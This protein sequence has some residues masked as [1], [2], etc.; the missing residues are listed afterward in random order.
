MIWLMNKISVV[1]NTFNEEQ[2]IERALNSVKWADEVVVCDMHSDDKTVQIAKRQGAKVIYHERLGYVEPARNRAIK[3]ATGDW[4]LILDAD[5]AVEPD[6]AEKLKSIAATDQADFV[7]IPRQNWI[8]GKWIKQSF[9]W[10][11]YHIRFYK[12]GMVTWQDEIHSKPLTKGRKLTLEAVTGLSLNHL[13]Y[14]NVEQFINRMNRYTS[15]QAADL[16]KTGYKFDWTDLISKPLSEFLSRF[17]AHRGYLDGA[18]GLGLGLLQAFSFVVVY[19][20]VW[21]IQKFKEQSIDLVQLNQT[22]KK[23]GQ[24]LRYWLNLSQLSDNPVKRT[25]QKIQNRLS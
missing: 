6:L 14:Q 22:A 12:K 8:F 25:W 19:L 15:I 16:D 1:I 18:H 23:S 7:E 13:H 9:W 17:F 3:E 5:E 4:L 11:D 10:P 24:E 21:Q 2:H 20:K